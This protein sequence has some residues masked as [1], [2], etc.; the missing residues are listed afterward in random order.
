MDV[1]L[2]RWD[3]I[4][5]RD[6]MRMKEGREKTRDVKPPA[7]C[8]RFMRLRRESL[9]R[10]YCAIRRWAQV[11]HVKCYNLIAVARKTRLFGELL[12]LGTRYGRNDGRAVWP[13][14]WKLFYEIISTACKFSHVHTRLCVHAHNTHTLSLS[15]VELLVPNLYLNGN[16]VCMFIRFTQFKLAPHTP[17]C[18]LC[19]LVAINRRIRKSWYTRT[20]PAET[21]ANI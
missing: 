2:I 19:S 20:F 5:A 6:K 16:D 12:T 15:T 4:R 7:A 9:L 14:N 10:C 13:W 17:L 1:R 11:L 3:R 18:L 21:A 8:E